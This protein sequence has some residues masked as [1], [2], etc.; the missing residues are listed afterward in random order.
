[1]TARA[2]ARL[3]ALA[4]DLE[5]RRRRREIAAELA[6]SRL[7]EAGRR[8]VLEKAYSWLRA[9]GDRAQAFEERVQAFVDECAAD[10]ELAS[11][12]ELTDP[13]LVDWQMDIFWTVDD[14]EDPAAL[15][16]AHAGRVTSVHVKDRTADGRMVD[17][18]T[19]VIDFGTLLPLGERL[20][21]RHAFVEHDSP[22]EDPLES[23]R[24]SLA[25]LHVV[26]PTSGAPLPVRNGAQWG[27]RT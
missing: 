17:V 11:A 9:L 10:S 3:T 23:A 6:D 14:G 19:G 16:E 24:R 12:P 8:R 2:A 13:A 25:H 18:G 22:G 7:D 21:L 26:A 5:G 20:G 4:G 15:L 27:T 1:M